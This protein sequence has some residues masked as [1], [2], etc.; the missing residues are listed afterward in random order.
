MRTSAP[1]GELCPNPRCGQMIV[2]TRGD[3]PLCG[4]SPMAA[5]S[6]RAAFERA[7]AVASELHGREA[8]QRVVILG[9]ED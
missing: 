1:A 2:R 5:P 9:R 4:C 7:A 8:G 6:P 3:V